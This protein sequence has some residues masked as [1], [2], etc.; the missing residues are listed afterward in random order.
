MSQKIVVRENHGTCPNCHIDLEIRGPP[1]GIYGRGGSKKL[2][3]TYPKV[4]HREILG[5]CVLFGNEDFTTEKMRF[6]MNNR[7]EIRQIHPLQQ[8]ELSTPFGQLLNLKVIEWQFKAGKDHY[9]KIN[10]EKAK[11]LLNGG[12][13]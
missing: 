5:T 2:L 6:I 13:F 10:L 12:K 4:K 9:Y 1:K 7:R 11:A 3:G 8:N